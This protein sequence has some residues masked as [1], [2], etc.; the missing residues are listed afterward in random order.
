MAF[1]TVGTHAGQDVTGI[2][3]GADRVGTARSLRGG[4]RLVAS[5]F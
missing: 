2:Y 1:G 3:T 5:Q 4:W